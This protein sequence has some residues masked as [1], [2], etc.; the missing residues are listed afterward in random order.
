MRLTK[1]FLCVFMAACMVGMAACGTS[2]TA[3]TTP[4]PTLLTARLAGSVF[5]DSNVLPDANT[6]NALAGVRVEILDGLEQGRFVITGPDGKYDLGQV[7]LWAVHVRASKGGW[8]SS[9]ATWN[10]LF[11]SPTFFLGQAPHVLLGWADQYVPGSTDGYAPPA[12]ASKSSAGQTLG[13]WRSPTPRVC[14]VLTTS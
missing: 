1:H 14:T 3:P 13:R 9:E 6:F 7:T 5:D 8:E 2:P 11:G 4:A 10:W 12:F